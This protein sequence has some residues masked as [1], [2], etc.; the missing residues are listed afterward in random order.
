[1]QCYY[2]VYYASIVKESSHHSYPLVDRLEDLR[3]RP[4]GS[5]RRHH[6]PANRDYHKSCKYDSLLF[7]CEGIVS[8]WTHGQGYSTRQREVLRMVYPTNRLL[9]IGIEHTATTIHLSNDLICND[10]GDAATLNYH[11]V[12]RVLFICE[13]LDSTKKFCEMTLSR[14]QFSATSKIGSIKRRA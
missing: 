5:R 9:W 13:S 2:L 11:L 12:E 1:M 3:S 6:F 10:D 14:S 8:L 4:H 7:P